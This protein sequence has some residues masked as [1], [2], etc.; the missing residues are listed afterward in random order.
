MEGEKINHFNKSRNGFPQIST[1]DWKQVN[2]AETD[3][4]SGLL[5]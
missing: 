3:Q 1:P 5:K 2:I 4:L